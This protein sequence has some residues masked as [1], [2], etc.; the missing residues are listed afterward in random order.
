[1]DKD[2]LVL[3]GLTRP[4][5][6]KH[7]NYTTSNDI[8]VRV[9]ESYISLIEIYI[10]QKQPWLKFFSYISCQFFCNGL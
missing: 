10:K 2:F 1:M 9:F 6:C 4:F 8:E 7:L 5:F 3:L